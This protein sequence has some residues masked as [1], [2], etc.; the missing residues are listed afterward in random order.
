MNRYTV[1]NQ[2]LKFF[3]IVCLFMGSPLAALAQVDD[4][5]LID[6]NAY[7]QWQT[8]NEPLINPSGLFV[9]YIVRN[10]SRNI[11][12]LIIKSVNGN[13]EL[14]KSGGDRLLFSNDG[15]FAVFRTEEDS[16]L[17][18]ELGKSVI[19]SFS[20]VKF[21]EIKGIGDREV[22]VVHNNN[23]EDEKLRLF[24]LRTGRISTFRNV[25][26]Y[27]ISPDANN[28]FVLTDSVATSKIRFLNWIDVTKGKTVNIWKG[29]TNFFQ[30]IIDSH[31][32]SIA[33]LIQDSIGNPNNRVCMYYKLGYKTS[34]RLFDQSLEAIS[35][36]NF[37]TTYLLKF[38]RDGKKIFFGGEQPFYQRKIRSDYDKVN[39]WSYLDTRLYSLERQNSKHSYSYMR[40]Y[41]LTNDQVSALNIDGDF[42]WDNFKN[43]NGVLISHMNPD[44][45]YREH[46][47]NEIAK[48]TYFVVSTNDGKRIPLDRVKNY[49][50]K[51]SPDARFVVFFDGSDYYSYEVPSGRYRNISNGINLNWFNCET[52]DKDS[53]IR[54]VC[55]WIKDNIGVLV[56]DKYDIWM[57]DPMGRRPA[58]NVT[59][60]YGRKHNVIFS[61]GLQE[62]FD[63]PVS[64]R[65]ELILSA[66][67]LLT[68]KNGFFKKSLDD[69][70]DP[71]PLAYGDYVYHI[72]DN[73]YVSS[74]GHFPIKARGANIYILSRMSATESLNYFVTTDFDS[75]T[76]VSQVFPERKYNWYTSKMYTWKTSEG[77]SIQGVL[78][79]PENFDSTKKYPVIINYYEKLSFNLNVCFVPNYSSA[80]IDIPTYV[81]NGYLIFTP[82]IH[83]KIG[84]PMQG[85]YNSVVS[86]THFLSKL[87]FIDVNRIGIQ[88]FS[89]GGIQTNYLVA[90]TNLF[91]AACSGS[92]LSDFIS[93]YGAV[94]NDGSSLQ[95]NFETGG[96]N[97]MGGA[98]WDFVDMYVKNS[99]IFKA[100]KITTPLLMMHTTN[101]GVCPFSQALEFFTALRRLGKK[102]WLLEYTDGRHS[103]RG[104][105][106]IDF[107]IRM[108]QFFDYYLKGF[109]IPNWMTNFNDN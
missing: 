4:K 9:S 76:P 40:T 100:N 3:F 70:D 42:I 26:E 93:A 58:R 82:D 36:R 102:V 11:R 32:R 68:K 69:N 103:I 39:I 56:Y 19:F 5:P 14:A 107:D 64:E 15:H 101:D 33:F 75:L 29:T 108:R 86:A 61:L 97:R 78:Y 44:A 8:V 63:D 54:G 77:L 73:A 62:Y 85:T 17:V 50:V 79:K 96:Q 41:N 74:V 49:E 72:M 109:P 22:I 34:R 87:S 35:D 53:S 57:L 18:V 55:G 67:G 12:T 6:T 88:G 25:K 89:F 104:K 71:M 65:E 7:K 30:M 106:A 92:G 52:S 21:Y 13:W 51:L 105:S 31:G 91:A 59:N 47:W 80:A 23:M 66:T 83:Y 2:C 81:S 24:N 94:S 16:L 48:L 60:Y 10:S 43:D 90:N 84:D 27:Q 45:D 20:H 95:A 98:P 46:A 1:M 38:S 28:L 99:A 37:Q